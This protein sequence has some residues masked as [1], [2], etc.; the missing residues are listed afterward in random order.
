MAP[1]HE[2]YTIGRDEA[3]EQ[4]GISVRTLDRWL[5]GGKLKY[6]VVGRSIFVHDKELA[7]LLKENAPAKPA[8]KAPAARKPAVKPAAAPRFQQYQPE[9]QPVGAA[10]PFEGSAIDAVLQAEE[11]IFKTLYD[12]AATELKE[13]Q[14]KLEAASFRV[15]QLEAALKNS[16]PLLEHKQAAENLQK[17]AA[18]LKGKLAAEQT[19]KLG[20]MIGAGIASLAAIGLLAG[21]VWALQF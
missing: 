7:E 8:A 17:E 2:L 4:L 14:E 16:V 9:T 3:A 1:T 5:R 21:L 20:F 15:G 12:Q 11:S 18:E 10:E 19:K 13:K 6:R